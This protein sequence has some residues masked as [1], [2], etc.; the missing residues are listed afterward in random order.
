MP[1]KKNGTLN[2]FLGLWEYTR[3]A[4]ELVWST[5]PRMA[6][7]YGCLTLIAGTLPAGVAYVAKLLVDGVL[8]AAQTGG[9]AERAA[10]FGYV[11][12][13]A[14]LVVALAA[15]QRGIAVCESLL[16][17]QLGNRVNVMILEKAMTLSLTHF[18]D[19]EF[20]NKLSQARRRAS[21]SPLS[22]VRGIFG[23][24]QNGVSLVSY[25]FLLLQFSPWAVLLLVLAALPTFLV[26]ARFA[27]AAFQLFRWQS[28]DSRRQLYLE[29]LLGRD[30]YAKEVQL[31]SLGPL[32]LDRYQQIYKRLYAQ[33]R[34][35]TVRRSVWTFLLGLLGTVALY[36][37]YLWV[38]RETVAGRISL[39]DM[40]M[41]L[42]VF[43][44]G[45]SALSASLSSIGGMYED[46]LYLSNLYEFMEQEVAPRQGSATSGPAPGD[47][48]R[49]EGVWFTYP[50]ADEPAIKGIDFHLKPGEKLALV[51]PNG[52]GKTTLIKLLT[53]LYSPD[54]GRILLDGRDLE[55]WDEAALRARIGVIFQDFV[56]YHLLVGENIGAGDVEHFEDEPRWQEAADRGLSRDFIDSLPDRYRTQLGRWFEGG[57][58]LSGGQWQKIALSRA[59]MRRAADILVLDEPTSAM[60]A[61]AESQ[62]FQHVRHATTGQM[63]I[64]ISHRF[65]TVRMADHIVVLDEGRILEEGSH[66]ELLARGGR[67]AHLFELQAAGYQ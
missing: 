30:V 65:S 38:V 28:P 44:Q 52:S 15:V 64:L 53:R 25:G 43:K 19:P 8:A 57:R 27:G 7:V 13:E 1:G 58:E 22:L 6:V 55:E 51:G 45:Q 29:S 61:E 24:I 31:F 3:R 9:E 54:R 11:G 32:L 42:L 33:D 63:A 18:E 50:G 26:E 16:R 56:H 41:Y 39:G 59:F 37:A 48:V 36:G 49:F 67:Y 60:D 17:A 47:G 23:L 14:G 4:V 10:A 35:L 20:Y 66:E 62:I 5:S 2:Q 46:N 21:T 34:D 12:L 40:S